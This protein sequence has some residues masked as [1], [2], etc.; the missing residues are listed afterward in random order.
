MVIATSLAV[1]SSLA[2][3][4]AVFHAMAHVCNGE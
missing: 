1:L 2:L 3:F 4:T